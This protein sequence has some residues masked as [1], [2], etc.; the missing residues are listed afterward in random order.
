MKKIFTLFLILLL[1]VGVAYLYLRLQWGPHGLGGI[2]YISKGSSVGQIA[3]ELDKAG[4]IPNTWSF[5]LLA[6]LEHAERDLKPGEYGFPSGV[7]ASQIL[8]KLRKGERLV[9]R[10]TIPEGYSYRQIA[11]AIAATGMATEAQ[12]MIAF[13]DPYYLGQ[14]GFPAVSLEG[15]LFPSTYEYDSRTTLQELLSEMIQEFRGHFDGELKARAEAAGWT[16]PQVVTL[17]SIIEKETARPEERPLIASVFHNRL[18]RGMPLQSDPTIIYG[19]TNYDG[20]IRQEDIRNPHPYNTYVHI[21]LPPGP[22]ASPGMESM[23]AVLS[24]ATA[25]FLFFVAKKDG[26]H[27]FSKDLVSHQ[28]A[29]QQYQVQQYQVKN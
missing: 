8:E 22:I 15:Y 17:A 23:R 4:F 19:L 25:D 5:K 26:T 21:G 7:T 18:Q 14:L 6:R 29:V 28:Q 16:I 2:I 12:V 13:N 20:N 9:R 10:L 11:Q 1:A 27:H 3:Q 24:P